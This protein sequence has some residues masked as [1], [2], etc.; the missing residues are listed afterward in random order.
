MSTIEKIL[1]KVVSMK[2]YIIGFLIIIGIILGYSWTQ[3]DEYTI[4]KSLEMNKPVNYVFSQIN[5]FQNWK[6]WSAWY[7]ED[8]QMKISI[9]EPS[10]GIGARQQWESEKSGSGYQVTRNYVHNQKLSH[11][12]VFTAPFKGGAMSYIVFDDLDEK[13][14]RVTWTLKSQNNSFFEKFLFWTIIE[15]EIGNKI[16]TSLQNISDLKR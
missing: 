5:D 13:K 11:Q 9:S 3:P 6:K 1:K 15:R 10:L 16:Q 8:P 4:T 7:Q 14:T 2:K 12:L